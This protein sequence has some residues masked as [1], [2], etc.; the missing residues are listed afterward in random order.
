MVVATYFGVGLCSG[1]KEH[2]AYTIIAQNSPQQEGAL[3]LSL[4]LSTCCLPFL[5]GSQKFPLTIP[6]VHLS[7]HWIL[8]GKKN[9]NNFYRKRKQ[10]SVDK[11][12]N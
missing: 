4:V 6:T 3:S 2:I 8:L 9:Q 12:M 11:V 5:T 10:D 1:N 7:L